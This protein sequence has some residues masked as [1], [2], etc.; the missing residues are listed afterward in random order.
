MEGRLRHYGSWVD[1]TWQ[2]DSMGWGVR[3]R[4]DTPS[5]TIILP[6]WGSFVNCDEGSAPQNRSCVNIDQRMKEPKWINSKP[7][8]AVR[9]LIFSDNGDFESDD[10][11]IV[12]DGVTQEDISRRSAQNLYISMSDLSAAGRIN[13]SVGSS[14]SK[15]CIFGFTNY[16]FS[17]NTIKDWKYPVPPGVLMHVKTT[18]SCKKGQWAMAEYNF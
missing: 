5:N 7:N 8:C 11:P 6:I 1:V 14:E 4:K 3:Y 16:F 2:S 10:I 9:T 17:K 15:N 12:E 13:S 18:K